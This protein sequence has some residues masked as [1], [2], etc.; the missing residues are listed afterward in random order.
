MSKQGL[1]HCFSRLYVYFGPYQVPGKHHR[2]FRMF[3]GQGGQEKIIMAHCRVN[4]HLSSWKW[5]PNPLC[6]DSCALLSSSLWTLRCRSTFQL[7]RLFCYRNS[8]GAIL[9]EYAKLESWP[10]EDSVPLL[11][12]NLLSKTVPQHFSSFVRF[13]WHSCRGPKRTKRSR[14]QPLRSFP[15][16]NPVSCSICRNN[17]SQWM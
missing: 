11:W 13:Y 10:Y 1:L 8:Q 9:W 4:L 15:E 6:V 2:L 12:T 3:R 7:T 5:D 17:D 14:K 16:G